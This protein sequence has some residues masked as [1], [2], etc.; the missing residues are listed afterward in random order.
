MTFYHVIVNFLNL[1]VSLFFEL[2]KQLSVTGTA[3]FEAIYTKLIL[4]SASIYNHFTLTSLEFLI[5]FFGFT[6]LH[7]YRPSITKQQILLSELR[8]FLS[9]IFIFL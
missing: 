8:K 5:F 1:K 6:G 3:V 4:D 7:L 2:W 9:L